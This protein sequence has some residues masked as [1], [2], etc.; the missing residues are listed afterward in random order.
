MR[1]FSLICAA[2]IFWGCDRPVTVEEP[3]DP[4]SVPPERVTQVM[5]VIAGDGGFYPASGAVRARGSVR[6]IVYNNGPSQPN[7]PH[8]IVDDQ[9]RFWSPQL[10]YKD[11]EPTD[12]VSWTYTFTVVGTYT[13][14]CGFHPSERGS[15]TVF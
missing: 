7:P 14:H 5:T 6:W 12:V 15:I 9:G 1:C 3:D 11:P 13:Y 10:Q 4:P 8:R 2:G